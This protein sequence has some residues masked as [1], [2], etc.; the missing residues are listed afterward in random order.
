MELLENI[1]QNRSKKTNFK[2][3]ARK[4]IKQW[5]WFLLA[6]LLCFIISKIY[7]RYAETEYL[8][9]TTLKLQESKNNST[10]LSDLKNLGMGVS[11]DN[12]L[13]AETSIVV[14]KPIL[15]QVVKDLDLNVSFYSIGKI[16]E[17]ELYDVSPVAGK[18][19]EVK[20]SNFSSESY[21]LS[22]V[23]NGSFRLSSESL[24]FNKVYQ[25]GKP[26]ELFFGTVLI[27]LKVNRK[28]SAPIK[29]VFRSD[30]Q[31]ISSL[32]GSL[33]VNIPPDKGLMMDI[34][35]VGP[36]PQKSVDILNDVAKQYNSDGIKDK[37]QEAQNT[38]D[39]I[40]ERLAIITD[41]LLGIETE[42]EGFKRQNQITDLESQAQLSLQ[43]ANENTKAVLG[44]ATQ[45][46]LLNSVAS[47]ANSG[48]D[49]LL[50]SN[51]G[52]S[53]GL[54]N[55]IS[56]YN[57]LVLTRNRVLKQATD[58][59]PA[60]IEMNKEIVDVKK[61]IKQNLSESKAALQLQISQLQSQ[62]SQDKSKIDRYPTQEKV[63]RN[64]ERQQNLKEQLYLYLLQKREENAIT[65]A[66]K[67]PKAKVVN[68]A[69]TLG[70][71][72]PNDKQITLGALAIGFILPLLFFYSKNT[73]DTN[74]HTKQDILN[75]IPNAMVL[76][77]V[78]LNKEFEMVGTNDF[79]VFAESFR[80]L[81][82]NLKFLL[83]T[84]AQDKGNVVMFTSSIKG[85]GKTTIAMNTA[86]TLAAKNKVIVIGADIRNPQLSR[87]ISNSNE[88]S[89]LTDYLVSNDQS[90]K[91]YIKPSNLSQNLD[92][93]Y[94]GVM[95]P[96]PGDLFE[97]K[98]FSQL[99][100]ELRSLYDY[101]IIDTALVMLVSDTLH[102]INQSDTVVYVVKSGYTDK[103]MLEF[104][105][106]FKEQNNIKSM[107]FV[108][109]AVKKENFQHY[110][111]KYGY[112][113]YAESSSDKSFFEK[114]FK[115]S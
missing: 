70:K 88:R 106:T 16:K 84:Q 56:K 67:A 62:I 105:E 99:I 87:F 46:S 73:L 102:I 10:A 61:L 90:P 101:V 53:G 50:P 2:R 41:E 42:K 9:K 39:F 64:I 52:L 21:T 89:G 109:N 37:N 108:L 97:M 6:M 13:Q 8:S 82:S 34:T 14:S 68:P 18:I 78:P 44:Y 114:I 81:T 19:I 43:N 28:L 63:F 38:Q 7:L 48:G 112:G 59:N 91:T 75:R 31:A 80:M 20:S 83:K 40:N 65:L 55:S 54:E 76:A 77:E 103:E 15:S 72:K 69:Y 92:V 66:V 12:E 23:G 3:E 60:V 26:I 17:L 22:P 74:I 29:V 36:V 111:S 1:P 98:K 110:G 27:S 85:E 107:A 51:I 115:K 45:L 113:Y 25:F 95:A 57:D 11:G 33:N 30:A 49:Q 96:N 94:S 47:I 93:L 104:A 86:L 35:M 79:S 71:V 5:P 58:R 4:Y 100:T 32:E 24:S